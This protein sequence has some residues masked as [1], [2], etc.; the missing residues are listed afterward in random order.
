MTPIDLRVDPADRERGLALGHPALGIELIGEARLAESWR[1]LV[2]LPGG[3]T[4]VRGADQPPPARSTVDGDVLTLS[5]DRLDTPDGDVAIGVRQVLE[6]DGDTLTARLRVDNRSGHLVEEAYPLC[7]GGMADFERQD[8]W[9]M[10][11]PGLIFGGEEWPFYREFPG[12]YLGFRRS[13]FAFAY[14]GASVDYWQQNLS[15]PWVSLYDAERQVGVYL[16]NHNPEIAFSAFWGQMSPQP[17]F[18]SPHGRAKLL[19]PHPDRVAA[20]VPIGVTAGW[21]HFPFLEEGSWESP[22]VVVR[23]HEGTWVEAAR[24]Y[25]GWFDEHVGGVDRAARRPRR[26]RRLAEHV[27]GD[28][29]AGASATASRT[30]RRLGRDALDADIHAIMVGGYHEG[31]LDT[32]YPRF[33]TPSSRLGT[34]DELREGIARCQEEGVDVILFANANQISLDAPDYEERLAAFANQRPDGRPHLPIAFGFDRLLSFMGV[35]VPHMVSGNLAHDEL[36]AMVVGGWEDLVGFGPRGLQIDKLISGEPYNLDFNPAVGGHPM[37]SSHRALVDAVA[38]FHAGL[39]DRDP[40]PWTALETAWDRLMPYAEVTYCRFFGQDHIP[41][42][43]VTFPEVKAT[44]CVCGQFDFGLV[45]NCVRYGHV[46]ALEGDYLWGTSADV[47]AIVPYIREVLRMR[48]GLK[49]NLWWASIVEPDFADV[50]ADGAIRVGAFRS[51]DERPASGT[52]SA[53]VLHHFE[54]EAMRVAVA[55]REPYSGWSSTGRSRRRRCTTARRGWRSHATRWSWSC[56][57]R[58]GRRPRRA[59]RRRRAGPRS[60]LRRR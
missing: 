28:A 19:W 53:L 56:R 57:S 1:L 25:R 48:R 20:D 37:S 39:Q 50:T 26:A 7:L 11:V 8:A 40:R 16:A 51:W 59:R 54:A 38:T 42:Q 46:L 12:K 52:R 43:E 27:P 29:R 33:S 24:H 44:C 6:L 9:R 3:F 34:A 13:S 47:P 17:D 49:E 36:R 21:A 4:V 15:M 14:P 5:W 55:V 30:C 45:N 22:P 2:H 32:S 35:G 58:A 18:A 23:F 10:V 60:R 31:G 41:V